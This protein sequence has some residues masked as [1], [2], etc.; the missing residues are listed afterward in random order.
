M[1]IFLDGSYESLAGRDASRAL[2]TMNLSAEA[3]SDEWDDLS[4]LGADDWGVLK[5]WEG[6]FTLK[7]T[8]V[9]WLEK[10]PGKNSTE[11][12]GIDQPAVKEVESIGPNQK[13]DTI[14]D[15]L[16]DSHPQNGDRVDETQADENQQTEETKVE[17]QSEAGQDESQDHSNNQTEADQGGDDQEADQSSNNQVDQGSNDQEQQDQT[18]QSPEAKEE[19]SQL[20]EDKN[21]EE[22]SQGDQEQD[23]NSV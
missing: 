10:E 19:E 15:L 4:N 11:D 23:E 5:D 14:G 3:L 20:Q 17:D 2:A 18:G 21:K 6:Q 9:G 16:E 13:E 1:N 22:T 7:Y 12:D 8:C